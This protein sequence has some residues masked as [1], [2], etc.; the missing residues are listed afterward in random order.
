MV[1]W[2]LLII[3]SDRGLL[4]IGA[5]KCIWL[6][7]PVIL[8]GICYGHCRQNR[9]KNHFTSGWLCWW[10]PLS[11]KSEHLKEKTKQNKTENKQKQKTKRLGKGHA[12]ITLGQP[13]EFAKKW[14]VAT[15][16]GLN[17]W[18]LPIDK[19]KRKT[20]ISDLKM[21]PLRTSAYLETIKYY[22]PVGDAKSST[23][24]YLHKYS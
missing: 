7:P 9:K 18:P 16:F 8:V 11:I 3:V 24:V 1:S 2:C 10:F 20:H 6:Q 15:Q 13:E 21:N 22:N 17:Q 4:N 14:S 5:N 12:G 19:W 23:T